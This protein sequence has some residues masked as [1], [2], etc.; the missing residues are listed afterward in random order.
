MVVFCNYMEIQ[1]QFTNEDGI[2]KYESI[3][4]EGFLFQLAKNNGLGPNL[5][6][7]GSA[8]YYPRVLPPIFTSH[9][10]IVCIDHRG[11]AK[12]IKNGAENK[13]EYEITK[14]ISDTESIRKILAWDKFLLFG[15]SGH[16][17]MAMH[18]A[19]TFPQF[20]TE[21][22]IVATGP[23]HGIHLLEKDRFFEENATKER[24]EKHLRSQKEFLSK[25]EFDPDNF[26]PLYCQ[27]QDALGLFDLEKDSLPFWKGI[28]T[29][30]LAFDY[31]FG[32]VFAEIQVEELLGKI[33]C[34]TRIALGKYDFLIAPFYTWDPILKN[35]P[36]IDWKVFTNSSHLP[37]FEEPKEFREWLIKKPEGSD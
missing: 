11:F 8:L 34:K 28:S 35:F 24:K 26:F 20:I 30:K 12:R 5:L 25:L 36:R 23:S 31:L 6:C 14:I 9:F 27:S 3:E 15:H 13:S 32:S 19:A 37:F 29:N 22:L 2:W 17:Y 21:L 4:I 7:I 33:P 16:G 10:N 18:Y 1:N